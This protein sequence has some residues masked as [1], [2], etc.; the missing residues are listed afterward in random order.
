MR[1]SLEKYQRAHEV[2]R[3]VDED[4]RGERHHL[5]HGLSGLHDLGRD[6]AGE[7]VLEKFHG[8]TQHVAVREPPDAHGEIALDALVEDRVVNHL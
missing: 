5:F 6:P 7:I 3:H 2:D 4:F 8:L 1:Q